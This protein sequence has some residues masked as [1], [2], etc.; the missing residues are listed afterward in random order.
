MSGT[1]FQ[2]KGN[3]FDIGVEKRGST[4]I[5]RFSG[6]LDVVAEPRVEDV[7]RELASN[8]PDTI[9]VDLRQVE[10]MDSTGLR[11]LI[12]ARVQPEAEWTLKLIAGPQ[13]VHKVFELTKMDSVFEFTDASEFD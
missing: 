11:S 10:F 5:L 1:A 8:S 9:V 4:T 12:R 3:R 13:P 2:S 6:E 7:F